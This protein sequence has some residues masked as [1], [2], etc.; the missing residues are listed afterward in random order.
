MSCAHHGSSGP[1]RGG[2]CGEEPDARWVLSSPRGTRTSRASI[3]MRMV[4]CPPPPARASS[5][6]RW[7]RRRSRQRADRHADDQRERDGE[8]ADVDRQPRAPDQARQHVAPELV[9]T[10]LPGGPREPPADAG[11]GATSAD[12]G[13]SVNP[14]LYSSYAPPAST[15]AWNAYI[16]GSRLPAT[17]STSRARCVTKSGV[18]ACSTPSMP[19]RALSAGAKSSAPRTG[20]TS[21]AG[22]RRASKAGRHAPALTL[23]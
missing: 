21:T 9:G 16:A 15:Y 18:S 5:K 19:R 12:N 1:V 13:R 6:C 11:R 23:L 14:A 4:P 20:T 7:S 10:Q 22:S 8:R 17:A 2:A 3:S